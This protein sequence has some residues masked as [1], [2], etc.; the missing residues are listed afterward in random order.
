MFSEV[1]GVAVPSDEAA[2]D[3]WLAYGADEA[4]NLD[5]PVFPGS[6]QGSGDAEA[7]LGKAHRM[8]QQQ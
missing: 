7:A 8:Y 6:P 4:T 3:A 5:I 1:A 2:G